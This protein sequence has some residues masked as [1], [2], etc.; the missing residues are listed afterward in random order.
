MKSRLFIICFLTLSAC[1]GGETGQ[2][3]G[4]ISSVVVVETTV[5]PSTAG[6]NQPVE[7]ICTVTQDG[8]M[9]EANTDF[10]VLGTSE[11]VRNGMQIAFTVPGT[12][13]I[14]C[15]ALGVVDDTPATVTVTDSEPTSIETLVDPTET[16]A[17]QPVNVTCIVKDQYGV[18]MSLPVK[19]V[20]DP[21]MSVT[22]T[23][24]AF[25]LSATVA[26]KYYVSCQTVDGSIKD[27]SPASVTVL[28]G[29]VA[30]LVT[31][32]E[33]NHVMAGELASVKCD[34][35]D[36]YGNKID[37]LNTTL[38]VP[39]GVVAQYAAQQYQVYSYKAGVYTLECDTTEKG[40]KKVSA[41]LTVEP[42][43][44]VKLELGLIPSKP[45]YRLD[46]V[47]EL[48]WKATDKFG[49]EASSKLGEIAVN[50][51]GIVTAGSS[52]IQF[53]FIGEGKVTFFACIE[54][55]P[56]I[57]DEVSA[58]CDGTAPVLTITY[59]ERGATLD[60][61][62]TVNVTGTVYDT[63]GGFAGLTING[64]E[65]TVAE[66]GSFVFPMTANQ[67][68]NIIVA[69]AFDAA[70]NRTRT[71]RSFAYSTYWYPMDDP[72]I[73]KAFITDAI[74]AW[75][76]D[77]FFY[78]SDPNDT[79]TLS[80]IVADVMANL[81]LTKMLPSP[82]TTVDQAGCKYAVYLYSLTYKK[83]QVEVKSAV[84]G[85]SVRIVIPNVKGN[86]LLDKT[87][88]GFWCP[89]DQ[90]F[91][92]TADSIEITTMISVT[93]DPVT[94]SLRFAAGGTKVTL[95][96][97][98]ISLSSGFWDFLLGLFQNT[99]V[100]MLSD[101]FA[102][103]INKL[104]SD[105]NNSLA[106]FFAKPIEVPVDALLP[107]MNPFTL[108]LYIEANKADFKNTGGLITLNAMI[109][110]D[111]LVE[112]TILGSIGRA[113]CLTSPPDQFELNTTDPSKM[114]LALAEDLMNEMLYGLWNAKVLHLHITAT[115]LAQMGVDLTQ[116]GI[117]SLDLVTAP[118]LP[119]V[120]TDCSMPTGGLE[121]Q[122][123]DF[124]TEASFDFGGMPVNMHFYMFLKVPADISVSSDT[125]KEIALTV[126][127]PTYV[128]VEM[129]YVNEEWVGQEDVLANLLITGILPL[130]FDKLA[131]K[132]ITFAIPSFNLKELGGENITLPDKDLVIIPHDIDIEDGYMLLKAEI[133]TE[134]PKAQ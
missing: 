56:N 132:P 116:Y 45:G 77:T 103:Q 9:I 107:G 110:T 70:Q 113:G 28:P 128:D 61:D 126:G 123:G 41:T 55:E 87:G 57:C 16:M 8:I 36:A 62:M 82:L 44:P 83:P 31:I 11:Y 92:I 98:D 65:V 111:K 53:V 115:D 105:L 129:V 52:A 117:A 43:V 24:G 51:E 109:R 133:S 93:V 25:S 60:G 72:D 20:T 125:G 90:N 89:G 88:G 37:N 27:N 19:V 58:W 59:P 67:G 5:T 68:I 100:N 49:N 86:G 50:P 121:L 29:P 101:E 10:T 34:A 14:A 102:K 73:R 104:V 40:V 134:A 108:K 119:P 85:L 15:S 35:S 54:N 71:I 94:H 112:R 18:E 81:D 13:E 66:D 30:K 26:G 97:F 114:Q 3:N 46:D 78:N 80:Y 69:E 91:T 127:Q 64:K 79:G 99:L 47:V 32:I 120:L 76:R 4:D 42:G 124:Y 96:K 75:A 95:N 6:V 48:T 131:Q 106:D 1:G 21:D 118:L 22:S 130:A 2:Q 7:V 17:G 12:Y 122:I 39:S 63:A 84:G 74:M 33:P 38:S 23:D